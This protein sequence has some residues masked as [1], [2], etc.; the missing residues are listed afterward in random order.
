[1]AALLVA[2][3]NITLTYND[4]LNT[5]TIAAA[6]GGGV[7]VTTGTVPPATTPASVGLLY[8]DTVA[9]TFYVSVG[10]ASP[11]DWFAPV[12]DIGTALAL[13]SLLT[14]ADELLAF[15]DASG[16]EAVRVPASE[17][18]LATVAVAL[19]DEATPLTIG[20]KREIRMPHGMTLTG[21]RASATTAPTGASL[22]VSVL[23]NGV[24]IL[25]TNLSID[26]TEKT[27]TTAAVPVVISNTSLADDAEI[28]F[29][30]VQ[31]GSTVA[32]TGL[33]VTLI[34]FRA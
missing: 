15:S 4:A 2:G 31:V 16:F 34:G 32:G 20:V 14:N 3:A 11:A 27:S 17:A 13:Q 12:R 6:G 29:D 25:S 8:V 5:H 1:V 10:T 18:R 30:V 24:S 33:K 22:I 28:A 19:S 7:G 23:Q 9:H 21:M 26:A